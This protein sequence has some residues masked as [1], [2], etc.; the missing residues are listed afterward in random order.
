[1]NINKKQLFKFVAAAQIL[2]LFVLAGCSVQ[3]PVNICHATGDLTIPYEI[4]TVTTNAEVEEHMTH[5]NDLYPVPEG[6][7]PTTLVEVDNEQITIC[8]A[9]TSTTKPYREVIVSVNGLNGHGTHPG[10]IIPA[11]AGGCPTSVLEIVEDEIS[12]CHATGIAETP[13]EEMTVNVNGLDGHVDHEG[14]IVPAP[15]G[16]CPTILLE[17]VD[18]KV[19]ICHATGSETN[20]YR[21][22]N[23]SVNGLNGH[24]W[25]E[26]DII[27][28]PDGGCPD[29]L[30]DI[31]DNKITICHA[32]GSDKNPYVE[33]MV[34]VNGFNGHGNHEGDIIPA[35]PGSCPTTK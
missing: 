10:D 31:V 5:P 12:I 16:G 23:V 9:T 24:V 30:L 18:G 8:H 34:S 21:E 29:S 2:V 15:V 28:A 1:M 33:I 11:P 25:H 26:G 27:P 35:V 13:Y 19:D 4:I 22:I 20:P 6:G 7:C 17:V 32:T 14:D 3:L